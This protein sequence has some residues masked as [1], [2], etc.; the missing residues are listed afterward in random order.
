MEALPDSQ[1]PRVY[2][3]QEETKN[4]NKQPWLCKME[5]QTRTGKYRDTV[6]G[7]GFGAL[8]NQMQKNMEHEW[9]L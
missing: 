3:F 5:K 2:F 7:E 4:H 8:E 1:L 9:K 6:E